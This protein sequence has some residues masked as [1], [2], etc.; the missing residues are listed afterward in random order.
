MAEAILLLLENAKKEAF[1][2]ARL[3][4]PLV[5]SHPYSQIVC[6]CVLWKYKNLPFQNILKNIGI[7]CCKN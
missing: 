6:P 4:K 3:L 2:W 5:F 1:F 7:Y